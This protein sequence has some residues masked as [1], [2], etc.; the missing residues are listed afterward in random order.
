MV[1]IDRVDLSYNQLN[2]SFLVGL[3]NLVKTWKTSDFISVDDFAFDNE[4]ACNIFEAVEHVILQSSDVVILKTLLIG[5]FLFAYKLNENEMLE[6]LSKAK[7]IKTMYLI[8]CRWELNPSETTSFLIKQNLSNFHILGSCLNSKFL[9]VVSSTM[10]QCNDNFSL[11]IDDP[12]LYDQIA[13]EIIA[14]LPNNISNGII[15]VVSNSKIQGVINTCSLSSELSNLEMLNLIRRMRT[16]HSS[17]VPVVISWDEKLQWHGNK[18]EGIIESFVDVLLSYKN[19]SKFQLKIQFGLV[20]KHTLI[21]HA[22]KCEVIC[23][24]LSKSLTSI[25]LNNCDISSN[26]WNNIVANFNN[27]SSPC[28]YYI[29]NCQIELFSILSLNRFMLRELFVHSTGNITSDDVEVILSM[30]HHTSVVVITKD[31]LGVHNPTSK[32][33]AMAHKLE[34]SVTIWK[35]CDCN[36]N[37][38]TCKQ[39]SFLL[40]LL[41]NNNDITEEAANDIAAVILNNTKLR[42]LNLG[43]NK[44]QT[45]GMIKIAKALQNM[46]SLTGLYIN[47]NNITEDVADDIATVILNNTKLRV[48]NLGGNTFQT[49]GIIKI[50]K[51]LQNISFLSDLDIGYNYITEAAADDIAAVILNNSNLQILNISGNEF[52]TAGMIKMAKALQNISSLSE[53]YINKNNITEEAADDIAPVIL[54]NNKLQILNISG[55]KFQTAG[56]I[57][58]AKA[59]QNITSLSELYINENNVTT[60]AADDIAAVILNNSKLRMLNISGNKFQTA[61]MIKIAKALQNVS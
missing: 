36:L 47:K 42:I 50:A 19:A 38:D 14:I 41:I 5:S 49:A 12:T 31:T 26:K 37:T 59:L 18:G 17:C 54:N 45:A 27:I 48:L 29:L 52:Q 15:L 4:T 58:I 8:S 40:E 6:L 21:A 2:F 3:L 46:S 24:S 1:T 32:Q 20:E 56:M 7:H 57:R 35:F 23:E 43:E 53:L 22:L 60:E 39:V 11:V 61:G 34:P 25:Y 28:L 33:L 9:T 30:C 16:L 44:F 10:S 13:Y 55:N 51:T